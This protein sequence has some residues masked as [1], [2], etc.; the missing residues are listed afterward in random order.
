M[1]FVHPLCIKYPEREI[2]IA[3]PGKQRWDT[4]KVA[5]TLLL[6]LIPRSRQQNC[7]IG[8]SQSFAI[9]DDF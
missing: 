1:P 8:F 7:G 5:Q 2:F 6:I 9:L 4:F 3:A